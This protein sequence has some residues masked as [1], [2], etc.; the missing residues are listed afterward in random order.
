MLYHA[1]VTVET[2]EDQ[3][4]GDIKETILDALEP[5][6]LNVVSVDILI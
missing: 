3:L 4:P 6:P 2:A 5:T 1:M